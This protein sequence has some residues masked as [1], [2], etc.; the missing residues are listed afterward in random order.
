MRITAEN[1]A[2]RGQID[3]ATQDAFGLESH[4]RAARAIA[5]GRFTSQ[6]LPMMVKK[7]P[8]RSGL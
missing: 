4:R 6:V 7:G 8:R 3:R 5:E 2:I 1:V